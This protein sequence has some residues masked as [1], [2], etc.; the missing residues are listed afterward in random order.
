[1]RSITGVRCSVDGR[2]GNRKNMEWFSS[3]ERT[4]QL[5]GASF[6]GEMVLFGIGA[7]SGL[8]YGGRSSSRKLFFLLYS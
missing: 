1:M 4:E 3:A 5:V 7:M 6:D 2:D 8:C